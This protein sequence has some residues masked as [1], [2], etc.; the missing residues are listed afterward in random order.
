VILLMQNIIDRGHPD[1]RP[2]EESCLEQIS[3]SDGVASVVD[4]FAKVFFLKK[5]K[6]IVL[7]RTNTTG[8]P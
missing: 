8:K 2:V 5:S 1:A 6:S 7:S 3:I 4:L